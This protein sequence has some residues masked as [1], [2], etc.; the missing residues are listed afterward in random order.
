MITII[1]A[2]GIIDATGCYLH[3]TGGEI[4]SGPGLPSGG[5]KL[6]CHLTLTHLG[7]GKDLVVSELSDKERADATYGVILGAVINGKTSV[8]IRDVE[9]ENQTP[10]R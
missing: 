10:I 5:R 2:N 1:C 7:T 4:Q 3:I 9:K 6:P 8:D